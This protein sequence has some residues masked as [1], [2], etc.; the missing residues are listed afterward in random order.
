MAE[1]FLSL[2]KKNSFFNN[3]YCIFQ[4]IVINVV[5]V[6]TKTIMLA[7]AGKTLISSDPEYVNILIPSLVLVIK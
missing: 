4:S 5:C 3:S 7:T 2:T 6:E 1:I